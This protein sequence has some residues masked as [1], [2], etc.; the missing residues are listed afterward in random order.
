MLYLYYYYYKINWKPT[1]WPKSMG[2]RRREKSFEEILP[3]I[4]KNDR[5]I[6]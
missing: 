4:L 5:K 6:T 2:E 3:I 1:L